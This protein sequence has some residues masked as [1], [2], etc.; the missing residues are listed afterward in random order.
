MGIPSIIPFYA[1]YTPLIIP[2]TFFFTPYSV[3]LIFKKSLNG[4]EEEMMWKLIDDWYHGIC[5]D[6][7]LIFFLLLEQYL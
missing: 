6:T 4:N 7:E 5:L 1:K 2:I 3:V